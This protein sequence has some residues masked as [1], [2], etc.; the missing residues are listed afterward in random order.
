MERRPTAK[1]VYTASWEHNAAACANSRDGAE[2]C[3]VTRARGVGAVAHVMPYPQAANAAMQG[4]I[5]AMQDS[6]AVM[7][8]FLAASKANAAALNDPATRMWGAALRGFPGPG[9]NMYIY[10]SIFLAFGGKWFDSGG[11][12]PG[13]CR[14][15][16]SGRRRIVLDLAQGRRNGT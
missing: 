5:A 3:R 11:K 7:N 2:D 13:S 4:C 12:T 15:I 16:P 9:Q 10:P 6:T 8:D 1:L 14:S